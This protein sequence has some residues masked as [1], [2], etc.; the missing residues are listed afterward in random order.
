MQLGM[1][2]FNESD[3]VAQFPDFASALKALDAGLAREDAA[4]GLK[5]IYR[6]NLAALGK[7]ECVVGVAIMAGDGADAKVLSVC[8]ES[9]QKHTCY[10]PYEFLITGGGSSALR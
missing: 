10:L 2:F 1:P 4:T 7:E 6:V 3:K 8:D 9:V 5:Q